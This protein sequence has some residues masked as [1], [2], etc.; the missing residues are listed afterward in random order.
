MVI[1]GPLERGKCVMEILVE[2]NSES[3]GRSGEVVFYFRDAHS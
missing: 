3:C 2:K 1:Q